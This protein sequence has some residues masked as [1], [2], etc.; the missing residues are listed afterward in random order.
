MRNNKANLV[1]LPGYVC[2]KSKVK[3]DRIVFHIKL[4]SKS[5]LCPKCNE[6]TSTVY[7]QKL[8]IVQ[9]S[10]W[11][12]KT[13][14]LK[15]IQKRF[16]CK[17]CQHRFWQKPPGILPYY[18]RTEQLREQVANAALK[19]HDNKRVAKDFAVGQATVQRDVNRFTFLRNQEKKS[20][21]CP[22]ILGIDE[23]FFTKKKGYATTFCDLRRHK[24]FD[25]TLGRSEKALDSFLSKLKHKERCKVVCIDLSSSYRA[26]VRKHFPN[27]KV[28]ADRFHVIRVVNH[29][30]MEL[31]KLLDPIKRKD[32]ALVSLFRRKPSNLA[33][34]QVKNLDEYLD[35]VNGLKSAY[36]FRNE[37]NS[38]LNK[39]TMTT[40]SIKPK[41]R[42]FLQIIEK[43]RS[44]GFTAMNTLANTFEDWQEEILRMLRFSKNNAITEG[45]HNKMEVIS[46]RAYGFRNFN[47]YRQRVLLQ[48]A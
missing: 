41:I 46:R 33:E 10:S 36:D 16:K 7:E 11:D 47:N 38:L 42:E 14:W 2:L 40:R 26:V 43:L 13:T 12:I 8:R 23:H 37:I 31:W 6:K 5:E 9:H 39:K 44:S 1:N 28:V 27:A 48:C 25:I 22:E 18:R 4:L 19:G 29:H 35:S 3:E 20:N 15:F 21:I 45:F 17:N 30:F 32:R 24:V 34:H